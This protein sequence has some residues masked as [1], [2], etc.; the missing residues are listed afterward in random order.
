MNLN[1]FLQCQ[2]NAQNKQFKAIIWDNSK[3]IL[4]FLYSALNSLFIALYDIVATGSKT[5]KAAGSFIYS[6]T[7]TSPQ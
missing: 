7:F 3:I 1:D 4:L 5:S 6:D 2:N